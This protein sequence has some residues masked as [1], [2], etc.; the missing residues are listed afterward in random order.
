MLMN[1]SVWGP[2]NESADTTATRGHSVTSRRQNEKA[3]TV[4]FFV[5]VIL[6]LFIGELF[7]FVFLN[8]FVLVF[9]FSLFWVDESNMRRKKNR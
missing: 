1:K 8:A 7:L 2:Q 5:C 4:R 3:K 6:H 9:L